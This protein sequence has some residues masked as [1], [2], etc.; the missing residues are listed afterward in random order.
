MVSEP[1]SPSE[2]VAVKC[3]CVARAYSGTVDLHVDG[4]CVR[5]A[6]VE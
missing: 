6:N 4:V 2:S 1:N 3:G 5:R